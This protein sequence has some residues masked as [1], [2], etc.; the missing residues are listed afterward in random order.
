MNGVDAP[1]IANTGF[2]FSLATAAPN[3]FRGSTNIEFSVANRTRVSIEVYNIL[4]QK[5]RTVVDEVF[6]AGSYN[7]MWDGRS[8]AGTQVS[9]GIYFYKMV[10]GDF[11]ATKKTV[12]LK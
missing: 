8:D 10:A 12:L 1:V 9:S 6:E 2:G 5:V 11:S 3:P 4:G 7:R